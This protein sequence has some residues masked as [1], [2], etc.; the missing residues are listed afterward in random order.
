MAAIKDSQTII[1]DE[2]FPFFGRT[3]YE[4]TAPPKISAE[5][6]ATGGF[7]LRK[8]KKYVE[9]V[10]DINKKYVSELQSLNSVI[11]TL[12]DETQNMKSRSRI[13]YRRV[14]KQE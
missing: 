10:H 6:I 5:Q 4:V 12:K 1:S 14:R 3:N 7:A 2:V 9:E 13:K 11:V 8:L